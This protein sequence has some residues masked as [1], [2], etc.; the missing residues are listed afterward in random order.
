MSEFRYHATETDKVTNRGIRRERTGSY[1][2]SRQINVQSTALKDMRKE[3]VN[4]GALRKQETRT[5]TTTKIY[6]PTE[7]DRWK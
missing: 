1:C 2:N 6:A 3:E 5:T 7:T 4:S